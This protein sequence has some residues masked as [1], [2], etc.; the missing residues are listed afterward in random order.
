MGGTLI[1]YGGKRLKYNGMWAEYGWDIDGWNMDVYESVW[2]EIAW[3]MVEYGW[4]MREYGWNMDER[5]KEYN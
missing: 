2:V 4:N 3:N 1:E 5:W